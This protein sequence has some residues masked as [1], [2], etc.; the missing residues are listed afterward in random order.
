MWSHFIL[1]RKEDIIKMKMRYD[2]EDDAMMIWLSKEP[3]EYAEQ[4]R[5]M[6]IH[7]SK[8]NKPV[9]LEILKASEFLRTVSSKLSR[10]SRQELT[11]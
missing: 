5:N 3:V 2:S 9:L 1:P 10:D 8:S 6:I 7:F 4:S 11:I